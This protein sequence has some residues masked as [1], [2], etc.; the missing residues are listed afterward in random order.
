M[1]MRASSASVQVALP[2]ATYV[3]SPNAQ[4]RPGARDRGRV[5]IE[6]NQALARSVPVSLLGDGGRTHCQ[7][8]RG[9]L[10]ESH[11]AIAAIGIEA[12][13]R[14]TLRQRL[15]QWVIHLALR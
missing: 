1:E 3:W 2:D 4:L 10:T 14:E 13:L 8:N 11:S 12:T 5:R 15:H 7:R 9:P 6:Q